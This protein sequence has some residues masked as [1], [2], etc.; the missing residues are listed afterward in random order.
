VNDVQ[1]VQVVREDCEEG[2]GGQVWPRMLTSFSLVD[3][4][5]AVL[6]DDG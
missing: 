6:S 1:S 2:E 4:V 5:C 3:D